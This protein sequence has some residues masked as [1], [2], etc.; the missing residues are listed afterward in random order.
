MQ[1]IIQR[2]RSIIPACDVDL[3]RFEEIVKATRDLPKVGAYKISAALALSSGLPEVIRIARK[4]TDKPLI[5]DHQKAGTDIPETGKVFAQTLKACGVDALIIFPLSGPATR[6]HDRR[7]FSI[8][9]KTAAVPRRNIRTARSVR[10]FPP[11]MR[12]DSAGSRLVIFA[13]TSS[14]PPANLR[15]E[16]SVCAYQPSMA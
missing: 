5:Y 2:D 3:K 8:S 9:K 11:R 4:H 14:A 15:I 1:R 13:C 16:E 12:V 10:H 7:A 6:P